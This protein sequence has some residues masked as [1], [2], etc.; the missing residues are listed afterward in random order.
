VPVGSTVHDSATLSNA[1]SDA[2]GTVTYSV[3]SDSSCTQNK[4]DAGTVTVSAGSV[5]DSNALT[6][7]TAGTFYW[8]AVYSGDTKNNGATSK[9]T[10]ETLTVNPLQ[11]LVSTAQKLLPNDSFTL[12]GATAGAGGSITFNLYSPADATCANT[13]AFTQ[14]VTVNGNGTYSTTNSAVFAIAVGTWRWQS[15]YTGDTNNKPVTSSCG[16]EQFTIA[17]S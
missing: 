5:P 6:F 10:D 4:R 15:S 13:P 14:T 2:G 3:Y 11:P 9:C 16:T 8:Q 7:G 17:N 1:T 12:S